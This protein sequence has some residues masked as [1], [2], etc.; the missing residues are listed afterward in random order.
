M[1]YTAY[2]PLMY[3]LAEQGMDCFLIKMP[4]N[5]AFLGQNKVGNVMG[6]YKYERWYQQEQTVEA[7]AEMMKKGK[8]RK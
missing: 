7:V 6:S 4:C 2:L 8:G 5:L 3:G 1:E